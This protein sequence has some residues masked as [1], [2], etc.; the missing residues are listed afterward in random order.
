LP[1][2]FDC[3]GAR[4]WAHTEED[5]HGKNEIKIG[6]Q[7]WW[8][9]Q[10]EFIQTRRPF[11]GIG[12]LKD[13]REAQISRQAR[14]PQDCTEGLGTEGIGPENIRPESIRPENILPPRRELNRTLDANRGPQAE[15][16][17]GTGEPHVKNKP[18]VR[19]D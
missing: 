11:G 19:P 9:P 15:S 8:R 7:G 14:W 4:P 6:S 16:L 10:K 5:L 1:V 12:A 18:D 17:H 3:A 13:R 2:A